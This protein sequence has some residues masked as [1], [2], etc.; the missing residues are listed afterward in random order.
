M[1]LLVSLSLLGSAPA[2]LCVV[3]RVVA[4]M[5][6]GA[7]RPQVLPSAVLRGVVE[8]G[9]REGSAACVV[10]LSRPSA[11]LSAVFALPV[12]LFLHLGGYLLPVLRVPVLF[13]R[14]GS[15]HLARR[16]EDRLQGAFCRQGGCPIRGAEV[17]APWAAGDAEGFG[18]LLLKRCP[19]ALLPSVE[20]G[21]AFVLLDR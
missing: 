2:R 10:R 21:Y 8:V 6:R 15:H 5:A 12:G 3:R 1:F 11:L 18:H 20:Q 19:F 7:E 9:D 16:C 14:H 17:V 4:E 13:H